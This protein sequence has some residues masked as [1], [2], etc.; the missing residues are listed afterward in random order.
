MDERW[1]AFK[2]KAMSWGT[3]V[4]HHRETLPV[5]STMA[6]SLEKEVRQNGKVV[7][8]PPLAMNASMSALSVSPDQSR[9]I[10]AGR[11]VLK[12]IKVADSG[13]E[14]AVSSNLRI[15]KVTMT[16]NSNDVAWHPSCQNKIATGATNAHVV[17]WDL[18]RTMEQK[19]EKVIKGHARTI[20]CV[21][22]VPT[23]QYSLLS[24]S[25]DNTVKLWDTRV[26]KNA[27]AIFN[28]NSPVRQVS[29]SKLASHQFAT[30]LDDG[31]LQVW[32][33]RNP[34]SFPIRIPAAHEGPAYSV[35]WHPTD[36]G[37]LASGGRDK[38]I[39][40]WDTLSNTGD[41][42]DKLFCTVKTLAA[43]AR[44]CWRPEHT[45]HV[46][47]SSLVHDSNIHVWDLR[48]KHLPLLSFQ[49]HKNVVTGMVWDTR[50]GKFLFS[51][52]KDE[53][54]IRNNVEDAHCPGEDAEQR[55]SGISWNPMGGLS[56]FKSQNLNMRSQGG[57][58]LPST[59]IRQNMYQSSILSELCIIRPTN[60]SSKFIDCAKRYKYRLHD[61][62]VNDVCLYNACVCDDMLE[63]ELAQ[64]WRIIGE[65]WVSREAN[66]T[67]TAS[68]VDLD[69]MGSHKNKQTPI[70]EDTAVSEKDDA[71]SSMFQSEIESLT[72][73]T[74]LL[75]E[76]SNE[77]ESPTK[78]PA[79]VRKEVIPERQGFASSSEEDDDND[80]Q[81]DDARHRLHRTISEDSQG[82]GDID[83]VGGGDGGGDTTICTGFTSAGGR[84]AR[85]GQHC[86]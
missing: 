86:C 55:S 36:R 59:I 85:Q 71:P 54:V 15:G 51:C 73:G 67:E 40:I 25:Q 23:E 27:A 76:F 45:H 66:T 35:E 19:Q 39:R 84:V 42:N 13:E 30:A 48:R 69:V 46:T 50:G 24:G 14:L 78:A 22:W 11:D 62:G 58:S 7:S 79:S 43:V 10:V 4:R 6:R 12:I 72:F 9:L 63:A 52:S 77:P 74:G 70:N 38:S 60:P 56:H 49:Q 83:D 47:S 8:L 75:T 80:D 32:D 65:L 5:A 1:H 41:S 81:S 53:K 26:T 16:L 31:A 2:P 29:C 34:S 61:G 21:A 68:K 18:N 44:V 28:T 17:L 33:I 3:P 82:I 20:N 57:Y 37:R 64:A